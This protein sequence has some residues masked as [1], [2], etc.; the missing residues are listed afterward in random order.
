MLAIG[1]RIWSFVELLVWACLAWWLIES[2][3]WGWLISV[4]TVA[5]AAGGW[6]LGLHVAAFGMAWALGG[7]R[8][9]AYEVGLLERAGAVLRETWVFSVL[10]G[11]YQLWP[12]SYGR[13]GF[14]ASTSAEDKLSTASSTAPLA[15]PVVLLVHG[16]S[17]NACVWRWYVRWLEQSGFK[18]YT[19]SLEPVFGSLEEICTALEQRVAAIVRHE[20]NAT[21]SLVCHSMGGLVARS[22][23]RRCGPALVDKVI[24][25]GTPHQGTVLAPLGLGENARQMRIG[26]R[27]LVDPSNR[28]PLLALGNRATAV[29]TYDDNVVSPQA[30]STL[31]AMQTV[32]LA[33]LGHLSLLASR[34]VFEHVIAALRA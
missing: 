12:T 10:F 27:W 19:I 11:W 21:V 28:E 1:L 2:R 5:V 26:S 8:P 30:S 15:S 3:E 32:E 20:T 14:G 7:K 24:T 23:L 18:V 4:V 31:P 17:C 29:L 13:D 22:Y 25:L 9:D 16:Y 33:G 34:R 6:R